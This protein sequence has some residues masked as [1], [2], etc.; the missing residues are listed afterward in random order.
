MATIMATATAMAITM[1]MTATMVMTMTMTM[2]MT[3]AMTMTMTMT[4]DVVGGMEGV[5]LDGQCTVARTGLDH[6]ARTRRGRAHVLMA[7]RQPGCGLVH[8]EDDHDAPRSRGLSVLTAPDLSKGSAKTQANPSAQM[9]L[10][11]S[12]LM[13]TLQLG[14]QFVR[15]TFQWSFLGMV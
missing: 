11:L 15:T 4:I 5:V 1:T 13:A 2:T 14:G 6:L 10:P 9:E 7:P 12:A 3:M 8:L